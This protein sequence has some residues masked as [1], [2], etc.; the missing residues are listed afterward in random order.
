MNEYQQNE[1]LT[2]ITPQYIVDL[3]DAFL[4]GASI[5]SKNFTTLKIEFEICHAPDE[6]GISSGKFNQGVECAPTEE[7]ETFFEENNID[8]NFFEGANYIDFRE[9]NQSPAKKVLRAMINKQIKYKK[10]T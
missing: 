3:S 8:V 7:I 4:Q 2:R 5:I 6:D 10:R 9:F 1:I